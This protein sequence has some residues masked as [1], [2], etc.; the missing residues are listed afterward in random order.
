MMHREGLARGRYLTTPR[1]YARQQEEQEEVGNY[2]MPSYLQ[3]DNT[4]V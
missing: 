2:V 3:E 1:R 4:S